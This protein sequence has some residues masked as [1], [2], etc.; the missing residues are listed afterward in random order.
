[1]KASEIRAELVRNNI[2]VT[3]LAREI[4][5]SQPLVSQ[6]ITGRTVSARVR[7]AIAA[8]INEP[9]DRVFPVGQ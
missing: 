9:V 3:K 7:Q 2:S 1:M 8:A 6:V 5:V 4:G